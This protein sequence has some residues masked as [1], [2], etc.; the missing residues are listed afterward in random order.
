MNQRVS[1]YLH[2]RLCPCSTVTI[3]GRDN[4]I[5]PFPRVLAERKP[6]LW[7]MDERVCQ[8]KIK[9][10]IRANKAFA[11]IELHNFN[12]DQG[13]LDYSMAF[14]LL[15]GFPKV[16]RTWEIEEGELYIRRR[17]GQKE[18]VR[19]RKSVAKHNAEMCKCRHNHGGCEGVPRRS[20]L[21]QR[22]A[23]LV[24]RKQ[25]LEAELAE[26]REREQQAR[27]GIRER[28]P[29]HQ[30][31]RKFKFDFEMEEREPDQYRG[32]HEHH[33]H[34]HVHHHRR[35][36]QHH[37]H[38]VHYERRP[39]YVR[40]RPVHVKRPSHCDDALLYQRVVVDRRRRRSAGGYRVI[41]RNYLYQQPE[42]VQYENRSPGDY[43]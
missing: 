6:C 24:A 15:Q 38:H 13:E 23:E 11:K 8:Y 5:E 37:Y 17:N 36:S 28:R 18:F 1:L 19:K 9:R 41:A 26:C 25:R 40:E 22:E 42:V 32:T 33:H 27:I 2:F 16:E 39:S 4:T 21:A 20:S 34:E 29:Y 7:M 31:A 14:D 10:W 12:F 3:S 30:G 43:Y 35:P